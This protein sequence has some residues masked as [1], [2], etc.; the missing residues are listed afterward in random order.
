[1]NLSV[2]RVGQ[3]YLPLDTRGSLRMIRTIV[4]RC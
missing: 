1:M 2:S 4:L 3:P